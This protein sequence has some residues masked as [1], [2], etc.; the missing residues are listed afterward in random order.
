MNTTECFES[1]P[2]TTTKRAS[3][4]SDGRVEEL[5]RGINIALHA[6]RVIGRRKVAVSKHPREA[7]PVAV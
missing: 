2:T 4:I 7:D 1:R 6:T 3:A 5:L